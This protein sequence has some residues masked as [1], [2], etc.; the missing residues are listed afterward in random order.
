MLETVGAIVADGTGTLKKRFGPFTGW[1]WAGIGGG[2]FLVFKL[3][4]SRF[5]LTSATSSTSSTT[6]AAIGNGGYTSDNSQALAAI[7]QSIGQI[8]ANQ[9]AVPGAGSTV[10]TTPTTDLAIL[11]YNLGQAAAL[12]QFQNNRNQLLNWQQQ[13]EQMLSGSIPV[14]NTFITSVLGWF[15]AAGLNNDSLV[16]T[17]PGSTTPPSDTTPPGTTANVFDFGPWLASHPGWSVVNI[18]GE[19]TLIPPSGAPPNM[20]T[21]GTPE[22]DATHSAPAPT[23]QA[24]PPGYN[25][26]PYGYLNA[27]GQSNSVFANIPT[28]NPMAAPPAWIVPTTLEPLPPTTSSSRVPD[29]TPADFS[30]IPSGSDTPVIVPGV[31]G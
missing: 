26:D 19:Q 25:P 15:N 11:S 31:N 8:I 4:K 22:Y 16:N 12:P 9:Q 14:N 13:V 7:Q 5:A 28:S 21:P 6:P 27:A 20:Y 1:Q 30:Y 10:P 3:A 18:N 24:P 2:A 29:L 17:N 23:I